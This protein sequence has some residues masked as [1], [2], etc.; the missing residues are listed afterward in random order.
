MLIPTKNVLKRTLM[1]S[2]AATRGGPVRLQ[3]MIKLDKTPMNINQIA[4]LFGVDYKT[5]Q[6]H[7]RILEKSGLVTSRKKEYDNTYTLSTLLKKNID[8][9]KELGKSR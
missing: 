8:V 2:I 5:A 4:K 3:I 7:V 9:L 1:I 6:H